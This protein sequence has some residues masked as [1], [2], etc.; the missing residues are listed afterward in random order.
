M[1]IESDSDCGDLHKVGKFWL[2]KCG[3]N[4]RNSM[5]EIRG[6]CGLTLSLQGNFYG[7]GNHQYIFISKN[8]HKKQWF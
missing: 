5:S 7:N 3:R 2:S 4:G 6:G 1:L 8:D